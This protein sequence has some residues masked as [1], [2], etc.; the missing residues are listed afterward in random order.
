MTFG[1]RIRA[2]N[3]HLLGGNVFEANK[4]FRLFAELKDAEF[5]KKYLE[6]IGF[7]ELLIENVFYQSP[8]D[9]I[10]DTKGHIARTTELIVH[11][12]NSGYCDIKNCKTC[13][14]AKKLIELLDNSED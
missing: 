1:F 3:M 9:L 13:V 14:R 12:H 6:L 2:L 8:Q 10:D 5:H 11:W 7:D 4:G